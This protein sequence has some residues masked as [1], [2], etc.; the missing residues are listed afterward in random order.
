MPGPL[1]ASISACRKWLVLAPVYALLFAGCSPLTTVQDRARSAAPQ[2]YVYDCES[3]FRFAAR[4]DGDTIWLFLPTEAVQLPRSRSGPGEKYSGRNASFSRA[5]TTA[6]LQHGQQT[7]RN[8]QNNEAA[9]VWEQARLNGVDFRATGQ[10]PGWSLELTLDDEIVFV[11]DQSETVYRFT[12]PT[13]EVDATVRKTTYLAKSSEHELVLTLKARP[14]M[15]SASAEPLE[16]TVQVELNDSTYQGCGR[17][18]H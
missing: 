7:H 17:A 9:A 14:C 16:V 11:E 2:T 10:Q 6:V 1:P 3:G 18:L 12:T 4:S 15:G 5:G 8:C 13:P